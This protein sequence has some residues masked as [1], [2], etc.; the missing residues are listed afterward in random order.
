[1][2]GK[3]SRVRLLSTIFINRRDGRCDRSKHAVR[4]GRTRVFG[5]TTN[6]P[7]CRSLSFNNTSKY[8]KGG[9]QDVT[10]GDRLAPSS[11]RYQVI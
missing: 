6:L 3:S 7:T 10:T 2:F 1:M 11:T 8:Y 4:G 5:L 9:E